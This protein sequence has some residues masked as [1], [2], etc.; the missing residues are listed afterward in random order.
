MIAMPD[1][2]DSDARRRNRALVVEMLRR[3]GSAQFGA[4][5]A[6]NQID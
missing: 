4:A 6:H 3:R 5:R 1:T 2:N